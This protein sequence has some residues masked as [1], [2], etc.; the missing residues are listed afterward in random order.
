MNLAIDKLAEVYSKMKAIVNYINTVVE[1]TTNY[2]AVYSSYQASFE[3]LAGN[4]SKDWEKYGY[5]SAEAYGNSFVERM[6]E[7]LAELSGIQVN[8]AEGLLTE[9]GLKNLG[10]NI[11]EVTQYA[12][13]LVSTTNSVGLAGEVS[14]AAAQSF[15]RLAG[16]M[17]SLFQVDYSTAAESLQSGLLGQSEA[18]NLYGINL[19][20]A[21]LQAYAYELGLEKTVVEMS[22][23]ESM[24]L[25]MLAI[26][27]QSRISWGNLAD[28]INLPANLMRQFTNNMEETG[29]VLGQ[30]FIPLLQKI[31][32]V[33]NGAAIAIKQLLINI[34]GL[35]G[36]N[37]DFG[38]LEQGA[39]GYGEQLKEVSGGLDSVTSSAKKAKAGLRAFDELK[40]INMTDTSSGAISGSAGGSIDLTDEILN[41]AK[42]YEKVW[43][44]AYA[45]MESRAQEFADKIGRFLEPIQVIFEDFMIGDFFQVGQDVS[46][47]VSGIFNF[48]AEAI[49]KVDWYGIGQKVGDFLAGIDWTAILKSIG[50]LIWQALKASLELFA[51]MFDTAPV[52]TFLLSIFAIS[53][54]IDLLKASKLGT[55][56]KNI[57]LVVSAMSGNQDANLALSKSYPKLKAVVDVARKAFA[58]FRFGIEN[59]NFLTGLNAGI[60]TVRS[61]LTGMQK[62][63]IGVVAV[64]GEFALLK[65]AFHDIASGSDNLVASI[66]KIVIGAGAASAALYVAFGPAGLVVAGI[67]ALVAGIVG[68]DKAMSEINAETVGTTIYNALASPGGVTIGEISNAFSESMMNIANSFD[69]ISAHSQELQIAQSNIRNT[70]TEISAI[71]SAMEQGAISVEDGVSRINN[72]FDSMPTDFNSAIT[73]LEQGIIGALGEGSILGQYLAVLGYDVEALNGMFV[74]DVASL[75]QEFD[76]LVAEYESIEDSTDPE[77]ITRKNELIKKMADISAV[78]D[79][80]SQSVIAFQTAADNM[81]LNM[82]SLI[83]TETLSFKNEEFGNSLQSMVDSY[84]TANTAISEGNSDF[85]NNLATLNSMLQAAGIKENTAMY[86][87]IMEKLPE[88]TSM[89]NEDLKTAFAD[90]IN[91]LQNEALGEIPSLLQQAAD[92]WSRFDADTYV[93]LSYQ[94]ITNKDAYIAYVLKNYKDNVLS[95]MQ[96]QINEALKQLDI[97]PDGNMVEKAQELYDSLF[98]YDYK[99]DL[100]GGERTFRMRENWEQILAEADLSVISQNYG[101]DAIQGYANGITDNSSIVTGAVYSLVAGA[102]ESWQEAQDSHSP[103]E[104]TKGFGKDAVDGYNLGISDNTPITLDIVTS[105]MNTVKDKFLD[106]V[107]VFVDV[108]NQIM[109]GL[110]NGMSSAENSLYDKAQTIADNITNTVKNT[111]DIHSPSRVMFQV[112]DFTMEGMEEGMESRYSSIL[113]SLKGFSTDLQLAP[114]PTVAGMLGD[115]QKYAYN[116]AISSPYEPVTGYSNSYFQ[117]NAE[118]NALLR[119]QN[120]ILKGILEKE[121]GITKEQIGKAAREYSYDFMGR[122]GHSAYAF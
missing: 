11:R 18:L 51:G 73:A 107:G 43:D 109:S 39:S 48:F 114:M 84:N 89:S 101:K 20:E 40:V 33:V 62:G 6:N 108:G 15:T 52:E 60:D 25:R 120:E 67:T 112:G 113:F 71:E 13:Q 98:Y 119:E 28:T 86:E 56:A 95:P 91:T 118:T 65:D 106:F 68:I 115:Y 19:G 31:L 104:I 99:W 3:R 36:I 17:A 32:P 46:G 44:E 8:E 57:G 77:D 30:I 116:N 76:K 63:I 78:F 53:T 117:N 85:Q 80:T 102:M 22:Q 49:D 64:F 47:L 79:E 61:N 110:L 66:G 70:Y 92:E 58:N 87:E 74:G 50:N 24:Q 29:M 21:A 23:M 81:H 59:G 27:D 97:D 34:A 38:S 93:E 103:S 121:F 10:L 90:I 7:S 72:A 111:L 42:E 54:A 1:K 82:G 100:G 96:E 41:A 83:D 45:A 37:I 55:L 16:D 69:E 5:Q 9:T 75:Q 14:L 12:S 122:T 26:L 2:T 94:G 105:Y 35:L 88:I 4:W